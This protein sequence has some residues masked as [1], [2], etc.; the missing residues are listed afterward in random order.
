MTKLKIVASN[1][2]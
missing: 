2:D 1:V